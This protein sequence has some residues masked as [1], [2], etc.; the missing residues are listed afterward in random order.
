MTKKMYDCERK[1]VLSFLMDMLFGNTVWYVRT[2][3]TR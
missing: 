2:T 3:C 1:E